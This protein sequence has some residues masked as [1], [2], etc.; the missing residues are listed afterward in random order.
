MSG[1][2]WWLPVVECVAMMGGCACMMWRMFRRNVK[3]NG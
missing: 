2:F 1:A 3:Q